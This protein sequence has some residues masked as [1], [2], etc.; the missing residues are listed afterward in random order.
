MSTGR[1]FYMPTI[2]KYRSIAALKRR[3][4]DVFSKIN[5]EPSFKNL[6]LAVELDDVQDKLENLGVK[7]MRITPKICLP[8][9]D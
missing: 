1:V 9:I 4:K 6:A 3:K 2:N 8:R 5:N 7:F